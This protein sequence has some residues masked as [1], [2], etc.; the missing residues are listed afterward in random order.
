MRVRALNAGVAVGA[1]VLSALAA[2]GGGYGSGSSY[3]MG[4]GAMGGGYGGGMNPAPTVA[5]TTPAQAMS[6]NL[7]QA[8]KL[9]WS[10]TYASSCNAAASSAAAG[11]FSGSQS[12][13]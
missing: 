10:S 8:V 7:G 4:G 13:N 11:T 1:V 5:F 6:V 12:A 2:C 9:A 3:S